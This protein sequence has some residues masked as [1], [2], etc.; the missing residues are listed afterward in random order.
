MAAGIQWR[1]K[2]LFYSVE[3]SGGPLGGGLT[4]AEQ[5]VPAS[6]AYPG[7]ANRAWRR[8]RTGTLCG[9]QQAWRVIPLKLL[10]TVMKAALFIGVANGKLTTARQ[11]KR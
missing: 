7:G 11:A 8:G 3:D 1:R 5:A 2:R 10:S 6:S 9:E 4:L